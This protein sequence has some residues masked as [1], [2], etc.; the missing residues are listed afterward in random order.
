MDK[1]LR[2][3]LTFLIVYFALSL[4]LPNP[5]K[6]TPLSEG[7]VGV[8]MKDAT[9]AQGNLVRVVVQNNME[10]E[11]ILGENEYP[12]ENLIFERRSNGRWEH[13][14]PENTQKIETPLAIAPG[15]KHE[16]SFSEYNTE[17]F[18]D[19]GEYRVA[20]RPTE[21]QEF[22]APF[23]VYKP[24]F[25][26]TLFRAIYKVIYNS[27][28]AILMVTKGNLGVAIIVI[29]LVV[30]IFLWG[31]NRK[32]L[33][34]QQKMQK[35]QP[36][37]QKIRDKYK[38][39][40]QK[41]ASETMALWKKYDVSPFAAFTPIFIQ[42]PVL[43]ALF[44]VI[45]DG[46]LPHNQYLLYPPLQ[47][48]DFSQINE[49][50]LGFLNLAHHPIADKALLWLPFVVAGSQL[51]ALRLAMKRTA[52]KKEPTKKKDPSEKP[53]MMGQME[54]MNKTM[55]YVFPIMIFFFTLNFPAGVGMYWWIST[56]IGVGQQYLVNKKAHH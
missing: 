52:K 1:F 3:A 43:I 23:E 42:F 45:R 38:N 41:M 12:P 46:L 39:D 30:K 50:F 29:T 51:W 32:S 20:M 6:Q 36:E 4:I 55:M 34:S 5:D 53:S 24:G 10:E 33:E 27:F 18:F 14:V 19:I 26:R 49:I 25:L 48:F 2:M 15:Q 21:D 44:Y 8:E 22:M 11:F 47:D 9:I 54:S 16:F 37:L 31:V 28:I 35:V 7:D 40:Q 17:M 13:I 56:L